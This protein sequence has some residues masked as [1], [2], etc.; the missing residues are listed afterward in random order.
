M[1]TKVL[2]LL[3]ALTMT[4]SAMANQWVSYVPAPVLYPQIILLPPP[5]PPVVIHMVPVPVLVPVPVV[6][7]PPAQ[8][9]IINNR[10]CDRPWIP[11]RY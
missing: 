1:K 10:W 2:A 5:P 8:V 11:T 3:I 6:V 7:Q 4:S 9:W